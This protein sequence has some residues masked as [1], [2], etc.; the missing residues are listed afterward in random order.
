MTSR[1]E[2]ERVG[3]RGGTDRPARGGVVKLVLSRKLPAD[4][5]RKGTAQV[6]LL[7][8]PSEKL[9]KLRCG[10]ARRGRS[11]AR[12]RPTTSSL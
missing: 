9:S 8:L 4:E 1:F 12:R 11:T 5:P 7:K 10:T 2:P 3:C 6:K